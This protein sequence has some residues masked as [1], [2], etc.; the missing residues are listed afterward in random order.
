VFRKKAQAHRIGYR[1]KT[2]HTRICIRIVIIKQT[3]RNTGTHSSPNINRNQSIQ[4]HT[5]Q[6]RKQKRPDFEPGVDLPKPL[7]HRRPDGRDLLR[8]EQLLRFPA[9]Y[10]P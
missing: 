2:T 1:H 4:A 6:D 9:A 5:S 7:W 3:S 8:R 10:L